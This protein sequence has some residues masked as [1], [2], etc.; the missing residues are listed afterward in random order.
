M[1]VKLNKLERNLRKLLFNIYI[2]NFGENYYQATMSSDLQNKIKK[3]I[4]SATTK[5]QKDRI[6]SAYNVNSKEAESIARLQ[7]FFYS[8]EL[9]DMQSFLMKKPN[10]RFY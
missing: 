10:Q 5:E 6:K 4:N 9:A 2:L 3:L 8:F 7:Q 1:V